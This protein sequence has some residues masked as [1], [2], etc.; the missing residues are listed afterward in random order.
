MFASYGIG[1]PDVGLFL[2]KVL[3]VI[4]GAAVGAFAFPRF[5]GLL[6]RFVTRQKLPPRVAA[7]FRVLGGLAVGLLV[8]TWVFSVGGEGGMGGSGGGWWPFGQGGGKGTVAEKPAESAPQ[9]TKEPVAPA[10]TPE[11]V[12]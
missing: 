3:A 1:I 5:S 10:A 2:V 7:A 9:P 4:G 6:V 8:W 12:S 11:S